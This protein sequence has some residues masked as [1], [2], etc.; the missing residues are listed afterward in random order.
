MSSY[1]PNIPTGLVNLD[2]DY[3]AI[4]NNFSQADNSFGIDHFKFSD[5]TGSNGYHNLIHQPPKTNVNTVA[6]I[7]QLF[8]GVPGTLVVNAVTTPAIPPGGDTQLYALTG[9]GGFS[10]LTG[11]NASSN[12]YVWVSGLLFQWGTATMNVSGSP[13]T[14]SF[15]IAFPHTC[16]NVSLTAKN[17]SSSPSANPIFISS[18]IASNFTITNSSGSNNTFYWMAIGN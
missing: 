7:N 8:V 10:Q 1:Q 17:T 5:Q 3:K 4:Q 18:F 13:T 9:A 12:G 2:V 6:G 16:F 11:H 15:P 14:V